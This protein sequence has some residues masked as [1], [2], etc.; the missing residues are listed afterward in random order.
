[1]CR[2]RRVHC[3]PVTPNFVVLK[4]LFKGKIAFISPLIPPASL[5]TEVASLSLVVSFNENYQSI[6]KLAFV[7]PF[8]WIFVITEGKYFF[9][10]L[11]MLRHKSAG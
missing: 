4:W 3:P 2:A 5:E 6:H 8:S 11:A 7:P 9:F 1:M 10:C